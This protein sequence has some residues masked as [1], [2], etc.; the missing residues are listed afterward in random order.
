MLRLSVQ[1]GKMRGRAEVL[2]PW[3]HLG[4]SQADWLARPAA[5][6]QATVQQLLAA[7]NL[8]ALLLSRER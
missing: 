2:L 4:I 1:R 6:R 7:R 8:K 3:E 5:A